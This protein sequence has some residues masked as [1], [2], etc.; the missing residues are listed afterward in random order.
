MEY[1]STIWFKASLFAVLFLFVFGMV[2]YF[3]LSKERTDSLPEK[4][5]NQMRAVLPKAVL[6]YKLSLILLPVF[7]FFAPFNLQIG[8]WSCFCNCFRVDAHICR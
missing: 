1:F 2:G 8:Y 4:E 6:L 5:K 7:V 3:F